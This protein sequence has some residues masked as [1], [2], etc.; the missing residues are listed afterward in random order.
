MTPVKVCW[1]CE[2]TRTV[3]DPSGRE[4]RCGNCAGTGVV[5]TRQGSIEDPTH[6]IEEITEEEK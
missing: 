4:I 2:G 5:M 3:K 1:I 6:K